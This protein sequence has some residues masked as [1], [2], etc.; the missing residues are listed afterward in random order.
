MKY[1]Y[2]LTSS[3]KDFYYEQ[4]LMSAFS[5]R[6]YMIDAEVIVLVD[7]KTN[8]S[9]IG[10]RSELKK[11]VS[12]IISID[13]EDK[14]GNIER[15]RVIKTTI[16]NYI[17]GNFLFIDCDTIICDKLYSIE[18]CSFE[19][20]A[21]LDGHVM[22]NEHKHKDYFVNREKK[23]GFVGTKTNN[24]HIN[25]GV[26]FFKDTQKSRDFWNKWHELWE[27]SYRVKH[28]HH[29]QSAFNE[30]WFK[31][32][33]GAEFLDGE[34]NCQISQGGLAYLENVKIIHYFSSEAA[35]KNYV[36]YYK[37]A[38]KSIHVKIKDEGFINE[39]I[40]K[41]ILS[42]KFQFNKV[43]LLNDKR[44]IEI[45]QSPLVFTLCD[46]KKHFPRFFK[47]QEFFVKTFRTFGK[48]LTK[49]LK[50]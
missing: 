14:V 44:I 41:M 46:I 5:L 8:E 26:I 43:H 49:Q 17:Q 28:D 11:Y 15:S 50:K 24:F 34:W 29:D 36:S 35:G 7:N 37:L 48:K 31:M 12:K 2:V 45:M 4:C 20:A 3:E 39:E 40:Q 1:V 16:P 22:L 27:Y 10:K 9:L 32:N 6:H 18:N 21:G 30:A 42:P 25:S 19:L 33:F 13:F 38:D 47:V 23:L